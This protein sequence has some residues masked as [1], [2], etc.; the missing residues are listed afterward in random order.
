MIKAAK[1]LGIEEEM[2]K[3]I[4]KQTIFGSAKMALDMDE[5]L[6]QLIKNVAGRGGTT[7]A[8]LEI[9]TKDNAMQE[10]IYEATKSACKRAKILSEIM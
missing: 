7:E 2:A 8:A 4:V 9:L 3:K 6:E 1:K 10:I 5:D